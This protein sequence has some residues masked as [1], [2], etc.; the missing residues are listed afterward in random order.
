[1]KLTLKEYIEILE[2]KLEEGNYVLYS[3]PPLN[4]LKEEKQ[5]P[6]ECKEITFDNEY[7]Y[8]CKISREIQDKKGIIKEARDIIK[9]LLEEGG[10]VIRFVNIDEKRKSI[11][12]NVKP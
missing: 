6:R 7:E 5:L 3:T 10:G 1:M 12:L 8:S 11:L 4:Y 9:T 2:E